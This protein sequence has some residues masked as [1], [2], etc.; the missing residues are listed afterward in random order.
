MIRATALALV[1]LVGACTTEQAEPP[2]VVEPPPAPADSEVEPTDTIVVDETPKEA[3]R[4]VDAETYL[5]SMLSIFGYATPLEAQDDLRIDGL[6]DTWPDYFSALGLPDYAN[7]V[8]RR[9]VLNMVT[10][11]AFERIGIA[12][13]NRALIRERDRPLDERGVFAFALSASRDPAEF[14]LKLDVLHRLFVSYPVTL[15]GPQRVSRFHRLHLETLARHADLNGGSKAFSPDEASW[16][17]V[18]Y[19]RVRHPELHLY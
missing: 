18:C 17:V 1:A 2:P 4:L 3:P 8:E 9:T 5:R 10:L 16:G 7:E 19:A 12:L 11:A 15:A 14:A 13:C 6:F